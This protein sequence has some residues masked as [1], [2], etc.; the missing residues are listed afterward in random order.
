MPPEDS[1][2]HEWYRTQLQPHEAMLRA[3]LKG[4]FP[5]LQDV[6]DILQESVLRVLQAHQNQEI[7]SPKAFL[8]TTARNLVIGEMRKAATH[9]QFH[10]ADLDDLD[11]PDENANLTQSVSRAE[12]METLA[13]AIQSLPTRC[14]QIITLRKIYGMS[15]NDIAKQLGISVNTVETQGTIGMRK[16]SAYFEKIRRHGSA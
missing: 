6:D 11:V 4:R 3:W 2:A 1:P 9:K 16:L 5:R 7:K 12:E 13:Q 10:L 14:R 8:F 15:Q